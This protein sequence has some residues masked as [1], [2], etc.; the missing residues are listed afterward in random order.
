MISAGFFAFNNVNLWIGLNDKL[1]ESTWQWEDTSTVGTKL[2]V[3]DEYI[4]KEM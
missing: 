4:T 1:I 3:F 2:Y